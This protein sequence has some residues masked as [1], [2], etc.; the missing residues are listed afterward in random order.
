MTENESEL[1][2]IVRQNIG[3]T[4]VV[5]DDLSC[6]FEI[7]GQ[8][9]SKLLVEYHDGKRE[10]MPVAEFNDCIGYEFNHISQ[11]PRD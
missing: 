9:D 10:L 8:E 11:Y 6:T 7:V 3:E 4:F 2:R 5:N 1:E